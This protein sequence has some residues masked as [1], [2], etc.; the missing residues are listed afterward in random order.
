MQDTTSD[1]EGSDVRVLLF[2]SITGLSALDED[3]ARRSRRCGRSSVED[4]TIGEIRREI[5]PCGAY[6][7]G[8]IPRRGVAA[9]P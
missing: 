5:T 7:L 2:G 4:G 6:G 8:A 9:E 1:S 3:T